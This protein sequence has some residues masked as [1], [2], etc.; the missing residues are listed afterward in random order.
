VLFNPIGKGNFRHAKI[1][2]ISEMTAMVH[3]K[4]GVSINVV[5]RGGIP[6]TGESIYFA[7]TKSHLPKISA[8]LKGVVLASRPGERPSAVKVFTIRR[9]CRG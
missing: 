4:D 1:L 7:S 6:Q 3:V 8:L 2:V 5:S 9:K